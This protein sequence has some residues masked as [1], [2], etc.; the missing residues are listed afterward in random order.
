MRLNQSKRR[1][2]K[3]NAKDK[4][5][6]L[7]EEKLDPTPVASVAIWNG[8]RVS[9]ENRELLEE[10]RQA[11]DPVEKVSAQH[12]RFHQGWDGWIEKPTKRRANGSLHQKVSR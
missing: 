4:G 7:S 1:R 2:K 5:A 3:G 10:I 9:I 11:E 12:Q 6:R 8:E